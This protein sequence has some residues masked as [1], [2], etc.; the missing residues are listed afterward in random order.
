MGFL[1]D[2][3]R[4]A[5][6]RSAAANRDEVRCSLIISV[7]LLARAPYQLRDL[8]VLT[9]A[10]I[11]WRYPGWDVIAAATSRFDLVPG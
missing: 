3:M 5:W 10:L 9:C 7:D 11:G 8:G 1:V 4:S 6:L 2:T